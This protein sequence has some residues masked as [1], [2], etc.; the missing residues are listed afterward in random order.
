MLTKTGPLLDPPSSVRRFAVNVASLCSVNVA[1]MLLPLLT[2]PYVVRIIG[3]ARLGLLNFSQAYVT[4]FALL[5]NYGF[6]IAAVRAIAGRQDDQAHTN[7][8]FSE[9]LAG[10]TLL[11]IVSTIAFVAITLS[12]PAL[13]EHAWL[14][15][16]TYLSCVGTVLFPIW[17]YQAMEDL[18]RVAVFNFLVKLLFS[19]SIFALIRRPGDYFYQNLA[20]SIAQ[21]LIGLVA[22]IV[23]T[24]RFN[25]RFAWPTAAALR[26]RFRSDRTLFLSS[27]MITL[28]ATSNVFILGLM[29]SAYSVGIFSAG[30]RLESIARSFVGLAINQAFFPIAARAFGLGRAQ[31][32]LMIQQV[33]L[34]LLVFLS[35]ISLFLWLIAPVFITGFYGRQFAA[36]IPVLRA[37]ALLTVTIGVSNLLGFH[38]ML[39]LHMDRAFF[40][41]TAG[42]SV[43]GIG[44]NVLLIHHFAELGSTYAWLITETYITLAMFGYLW[45]RGVRVWNLAA[46]GGSLAFGQ[47]ELK[48]FFQ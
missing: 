30:I 7:R 12:T 4:Y 33:F 6:E 42:G 35:L 46:L 16:G 18:G 44:L 17:L 37:A 20:L 39:N 23:A 22:L 19:V 36:A 43:I 10:K 24:R 11:W 41:I 13:R 5:I 47:R 9:V 26:R 3:P 40:A 32:L 45:W 38:V 21:V 28:Y 14:H 15:A 48:R 2:V 27:V 8:I 1:N 25:V 29:S 31:G 34:P